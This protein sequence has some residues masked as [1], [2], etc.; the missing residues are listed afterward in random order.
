MSLSVPESLLTSEELARITLFSRDLA[1]SL[2]EALAGGSVASSVFNVRDYGAR[3]DGVTDDAA[4]VQAAVTAAIASGTGGQILFPNGTYKLNSYV[5]VNGASGL[6]FSGTGASTIVYPSDN[7]ALVT[8]GVALNDG[9]ARSGFLV[10]NSTKVSFDYLTFQGGSSGEISTVN[11]GAGVYAYNTSYILMTSCNAEGGYHAFSQD[12]QTNDIGARI[13]GNSFHNCRGVLRTGND[14]LIA[15]NVDIIDGNADVTGIGQ[16]FAKVGSTITLTDSS[17]RFESWMN[18]RYIWIASAT[19]PANNG[20]KLVTYISASQVSWTDASGVTEAFT[21]T[22]WV[23]GGEKGSYGVS[24]SFSG[25]V[26]TLVSA[27]AIFVAADVNKAIRLTQA[28][29]PANSGVFR[30]STYVSATTVRFNNASGVSEGYTGDFTVD[31]YDNVIDG[32][33][34]GSTHGF[35]AFGGRENIRIVYNVFKGRRT[36]CVKA[37]GSSAPVRNLTAQ[38]NLA[39]ECGSFAVLGADDSQIHENFDIDGNTIVDCA[40]GRYGWSESIGVLILGARGVRVAN[41]TFS[42]TRNSIR[43]VDGSASLAG[44][45]AVQGARYVD[46]Q[47]QPLEDISII[48]N[49]FSGWPIGA[50]PSS[51]LSAAI[52]LED[53]GLLQRHGIGATLT[54]SGSTMTLSGATL[55]TQE[56]VGASLQ[57]V[58][59]ASGNDGT[60]TITSVPSTTSLTYVNAGGTGGGVSA[61]VYRIGAPRGRGGGSCLVMNNEILNVA[62]N[63]MLLESN[64]SPT[65]H[66]NSF[67]GCEVN[68]QMEGDLAPDFRF[69]REIGRS[70]DTPGIRMNGVDAR[71]SWPIISDNATASQSVGTSR[72][73]GMQIGI[74]GGTPV[75]FPLLGTHGR[76]LPSDG[77]EEVVVAW[78]SKHTYGTTITVDPGA[79]PVTYTYTPFTPGVNEFKTMAELIALIDAQAGVDCA[80][81]GTGFKDSAGSAAN[82]DTGHLRI[83]AAAASA[84]TDGTLKVTVSALYPTEL[85]VLSNTVSPNNTCG[86]RGSGSAGPT[87][88]KVVIWSQMA[89]F[90]DCPYLLGDNAAAQTVL[91]ANGFRKLSTVDGRDSGSTDLLVTGTTAG[92]EQFRWRVS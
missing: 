65:I 13:V 16:S 59:S 60:Y 17:A 5:L 56:M 41:N 29:T 54:K 38:G 46:G 58:G 27:E 62:A 69:N 10:I 81:Y 15:M 70:S 52:S 55:F 79:S 47:S 86:G 72:G 43:A 87:A 34:Y 28:T 71:V 90:D 11:I 51:I 12:L 45:Y 40:T 37:S 61:G 68:V 35:Y 20:R 39:I 24:L 18:N 82:V 89:S 31:G 77:K 50:S 6:R 66:G 80:D 19:S 30:I 88:D 21:G 75:D 14:A 32:S 26:V 48:A 73:W 85:V 44:L 3:G 84:N 53:V 78:G 67:L 64:V 63:G 42:Y 25:G 49:K 57:L 22:W 8:S 7:T 92:T 23:P 2:D 1:D 4:A 76:A 74:N 36:T 91:Q 83:R 33:T 9:Q